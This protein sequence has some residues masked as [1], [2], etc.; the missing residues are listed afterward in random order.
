MKKLTELFNTF[1]NFTDTDDERNK[2]NELKFQMT[3]IPSLFEKHRLE[4]CQY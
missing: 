1:I 4:K 3:V 2:I